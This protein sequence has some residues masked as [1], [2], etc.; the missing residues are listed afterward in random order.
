MTL[1]EPGMVVI[2]WLSSA[3]PAGPKWHEIAASDQHK[4]GV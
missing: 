3:H 1:S 4:A 2:I